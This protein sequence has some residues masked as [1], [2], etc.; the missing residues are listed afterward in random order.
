MQH[1]F[2]SIIVPVYN[3]ERYLPSCLDSIARLSAVEWE[4]VIIDDGSTD[5]SG[6]VC[7]NYA[8]RD[9]RFRVIHQQ[10]AGVSAA[11]NAGLDA[12][13]GEWIWFVDGD[14]IVNTSCMPAACQWLRQHPSV[15][16][17]MF[18]FLRFNDGDEIND[19]EQNNINRQ[20]SS[21]QL[22]VYAEKTKN[23]FLLNHLCAYHWLLWYRRDIIERHGIRFSL[24]IRNSEDGEFMAK[25]LML[26]LHP[27]GIDEIVYYYRMREGSAMHTSNVKRNIV[28]DVPVV[29]FH[30]I[31]WM[32]KV[33]QKPEPWINYWFM[34]MLQNLL[35]NAFQYADLDK[36]IFQKIVREMLHACRAC[37]LT[38]VDS[39]KMRLAAYNVS[40]Y[41]ILNK[42]YMKVKSM[43]NKI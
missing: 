20:S 3:V 16:Y 13:H 25:Y 40:V 7:D 27:V 15:D 42:L 2:L 43:K 17:V 23:D 24:G 11:R 8:A 5:S 14:D 18:N 36:R 21:E 9:P 39:R 30:L 4:A 41:F 19:E 1:I 33:G 22:P 6:D 38:F 31:E 28:E 10:N 12:A 29:F 35:V 26:M 32:K 37:G 34:K